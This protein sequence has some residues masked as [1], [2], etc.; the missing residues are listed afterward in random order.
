MK[1]QQGSYDRPQQR[2]PISHYEVNDMSDNANLPQQQ[3]ESFRSDKFI[4]IYSNSANLGV[5][6]WDFRLTFG[7]LRPE[8]NNKPPKIEQLVGVVMSPPHT[9]ALLGVLANYVQEYEKNV[10]EIKLPQPQLTVA[11]AKTQ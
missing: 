8:T 9:K 3:L 4:T 7:E 10:G 11:P 1:H 2:F 5:T 6:P